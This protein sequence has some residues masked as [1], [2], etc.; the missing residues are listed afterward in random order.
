MFFPIQWL[1]RHGYS[2]KMW[3]SWSQYMHLSRWLSQECQ[4]LID[5]NPSDLQVLQWVQQKVGVLLMPPLL[6][7]QFK[8][9]MLQFSGSKSGVSQDLTLTI[10]V[11]CSRDK[12]FAS[13]HFFSQSYKDAATSLLPLT[14]WWGCQGVFK[15]AGNIDLSPRRQSLDFH[16]SDPWMLYD[17]ASNYQEPHRCFCCP[18]S[19]GIWIAMLR[20]H[21]LISRS[22]T[23]CHVTGAC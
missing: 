9:P 23:V 14:Y 13:D 5:T 7:Q 12:S 4:Q 2:A 17:C 21:S 22:S 15:G 20:E 11:H 1:N 6:Q 3:S 19:V 8:I 10:I 16:S 18:S